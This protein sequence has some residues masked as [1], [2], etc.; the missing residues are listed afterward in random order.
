M[1][2]I[3]RISKD[4]LNPFFRLWSLTPVL[5]ARIGNLSSGG[6]LAVKEFQDIPSAKKV[7]III[8]WESKGLLLIDYLEKRQTINGAYY[9]AFLDKV[10][11][12]I[13]EKGPEITRK[14]VQFHHDDALSLTNHILVGKTGWI[15]IPDYV[16]TTLF[17]RSSTLRLP[18]IPKTCPS[19]KDEVVIAEVFWR[20]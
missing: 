13:S 1:R 12:A 6:I 3:A 10:K 7:M 4:N 15:T 9:T 2:E 14:K 16:P 5:C 11:I 20:V 17:T 19:S 8:F 18:L